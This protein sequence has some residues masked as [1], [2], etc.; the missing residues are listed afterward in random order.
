MNTLWFE[1]EAK[2]KEQIG[3]SRAEKPL[4][5]RQGR[6]GVVEAVGELRF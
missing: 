3:F 5:S 6:I 2:R 4:E 1:A